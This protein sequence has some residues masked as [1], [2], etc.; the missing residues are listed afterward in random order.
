MGKYLIINADDFG[1]AEGVN[2]GII[3][4]HEHG[5]VLSTSLMVDMPAAREAAMLAKAHPQLGVG[6]HF[7]V[8][9]NNGSAVD[10]FDLTAI[11]TKLNRQYERCCELLGRPPTHVDSHH[12][13]HLRKELTPLFAEWARKRNLP[14]RSLGSVSYNGSFY[15]H[16]YDEEW[17]PHPAPELISIKNLEKILRELPDGATELSCHPAYLSSD[18][19]SSYAT[20]REIELATLVDPHMLTVIDELEI[21]VTNFAALPKIM[22]KH[23]VSI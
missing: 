13:V 18:L 1:Y 20:E 9:D 21:T 19:R 22:E 6:L 4:A 16:W 11:K 5:I 17:R 2:R 12:H 3:A 23:N 8:T 7:T 10:P 15:G 14:V